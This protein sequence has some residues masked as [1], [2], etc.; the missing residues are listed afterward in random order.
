M[1]LEKAR[2]ILAA[3]KEPYTKE[4]EYALSKQFCQEYGDKLLA[5]AD[6]VQD[7]GLITPDIERA[8]IALNT[9]FGFDPAYGEDK[10]CAVSAILKDGVL[11]VTDIK[12][13]N[14]ELDWL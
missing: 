10:T 12:H 2:G 9:Y 1:S 11:V 4:E 5:V 6:A 14:D 7:S 8:L 13:G 3:F